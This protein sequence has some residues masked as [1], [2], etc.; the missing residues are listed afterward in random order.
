MPAQ[1]R[2]G[3]SQGMATQCSGQPSDEGRE[4][5]PVRPVHAWSWVGAAEHGDL[6]AQHEEL[7]V[8]GGGRATR[9]QDQPENTPEASSREA[10]MTRRDHVRPVITAGQRPGPTS[11]IPQT[12]LRNLVITTLRLARVTNVAAALRRH[13]LDPHRPLTAKRSCSDFALSPGL[14]PGSEGH[15][16]RHPQ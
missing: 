15:S 14:L 10:A 2:V 11:G 12:A 8:L 7:D 4:R 1:D 16:S 5:S 9:Q 6:V 13:A 3:A